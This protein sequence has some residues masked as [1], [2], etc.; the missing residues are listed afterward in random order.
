MKWIGFIIGFAGF[1]WLMYIDWRIAAA[2]FI[3][4]WGDNL[5]KICG[6]KR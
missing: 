3:M 2:V 1:I 4:M 6:G 5:D